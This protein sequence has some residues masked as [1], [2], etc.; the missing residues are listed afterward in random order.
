V[1]SRPTPYPPKA[2]DRNYR[3]KATDRTKGAVRPTELEAE[4][5]PT[6]LAPM[7]EIGCEDALADVL[8]QIYAAA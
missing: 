8:D 7:W 1:L 5:L 6:D 4:P 2:A 3:V